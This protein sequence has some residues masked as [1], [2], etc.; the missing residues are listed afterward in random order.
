MPHLTNRTM[1]MHTS[2][3]AVK[4]AVPLVLLGSL[5]VLGSQPELRTAIPLLIGVTAFMT[6]VLAFSRF[7][8]ENRTDVWT[9]AMILAVALGL[10]LLLVFNPPQLSDD[11]NRYLWDG[12]NLLKGVN[13]YAAAPAAVVPAPELSVLHAQINHPQYVTIYPPA[14][15]LLFAAGAVPGG[16]TTGLKLLLLLFDMGLCA[17]LVML[18]QRLKLPA[19][20]A[21]LYAWNPLPVVEIAGSGHIDGAGLTLLLASLCLIMSYRQKRDRERLPTWPFLLSG[22]LFATAVLVKLYPLLFAPLLLLLAPARRR[23]HLSAGFLTVLAALSLPFMPQL[24]KSGASLEAYARNW[25]FAGLAFTMLRSLSGSGTT[26][27]LILSAGCAVAVAAIVIRCSIRMRAETTAAG[28]GGQALHACYAIALSLLLLTPTL[29]P[30]YALSLAVFLPFCAGPAGL[31]LCWTAFL[32]YQVQIGYFIEGKWTENLW[33]TAAVCLAP[34]TAA[35][36]GKLFRRFQPP[37]M[38]PT[39]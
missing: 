37:A 25:E 9:P 15:Q 39:Q 22:A 12:S 19:W 29:Q 24:I 36:L 2:G 17:L 34:L 27:R 30:W 8:F 3:R 13:P 5:G 38:E 26:A 11:I 21:V 35:L 28:Q 33:V 1:T 18:L 10:R 32:T 4:F 16:T 7:Y 14:A 23:R 31:I 20:Q 6:T